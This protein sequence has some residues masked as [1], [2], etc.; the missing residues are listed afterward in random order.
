MPDP[1]TGISQDV[2]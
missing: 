1:V 2:R